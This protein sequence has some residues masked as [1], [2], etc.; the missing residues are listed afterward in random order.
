MT[1][2]VAPFRELDEKG[3]LVSLNFHD[4][5]IRAFESTRRFVAMLA[6][7]QGGKTCFGPHWLEN[8]IIK[9][10]NRL[11]VNTPNLKAIG[12]LLAV[13]STY[14]M[15]KLKMLPELQE[16]F[17][18][19]S[20]IG[21]YWPGE[22]IMELRES[23]GHKFLAKH[24]E[25]KMWGRIIL[26]SADAKYGLESATCF[27]AWLD[28]AGQ[29]S[30]GRDAWD[31]V[32]RR[33]SLSMGRILI[34]T[35]LYEWGWLKAEVYDRWM[36]GD[37]NI[38]VIQFDSLVNPAFPRAEY[39]RARDTTPIWKFNLM[40]RGMYDKPAGMIYDCF[41]ETVCVIDRTRIDDDCLWYVGHDFGSSNP[42]AMFYAV[43]P[44]TG[45]IWAVHEYLP[46]SK[47]I[48][49][50]VED[51]KEITK[52][53]IV[54][55]RIGGSHQ[56]QGW[57]DAYAAQGWPIQEPSEHLRNVDVAIGKVYALH[58]HNRI[59]AFRDLTNYLD[60]K[61]AY[62]YELDDKFQPTNE[63]KDKARFHL[64]DAER[65]ILS[66]FVPETVASGE[67]PEATDYM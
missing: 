47:T 6:G 35:T 37:T 39:N 45:Y 66:D 31:A 23:P 40:Y 20:G 41:D 56:E 16:V 64:M 36:A 59:F 1:T 53:R 13:T 33:L 38:D 63:I 22:R 26:R 30:F 29:P 34:T 50:Q 61:R 24:K 18:H 62:S 48:Y 11:R 27:A 12:D 32:L 55:K 67:A 25:D 42:G 3:Q 9:Q 60:Q 65:Y 44:V 28:E 43:Q 14:D 5:Q 15:F 46:G 52:D 51:F 57:R 58:K 2:T 54:F 19:L 10:T 21:R 8:E 7:P 49:Q 17:E 4:G